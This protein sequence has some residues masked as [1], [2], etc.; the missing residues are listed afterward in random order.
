MWGTGAV[1]AGNRSRCRI[2]LERNLIADDVSG[3][4]EH[5]VFLNTLSLEEQS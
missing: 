3:T 4:M 5:V 2:V 1:P